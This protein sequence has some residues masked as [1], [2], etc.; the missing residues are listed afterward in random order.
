MEAQRFRGRMPTPLSQQPGDGVSSDCL[1]SQDIV[2]ASSQPTRHRDANLPTQTTRHRLAVD[3]HDSMDDM[4]ANLR[5][6]DKETMRNLRFT[7]LKKDVSN[8]PMVN[9]LAAIKITPTSTDRSALLHKDPPFITTPQGDSVCGVVI[10]LNALCLGFDVDQRISPEG[11][12]PTTQVLLTVFQNVFLALFVL[13]VCV[14]TKAEGW[15]YLKSTWGVFDVIVVAISVVDVWILEPLA[16]DQRLKEFSV[17]RILRLLRLARIMRLFHVCKELYLLASGLVASFSSVCWVFCLLFI[18][19]YMGA[20]FCTSL[21]GGQDDPELQ[22]YFGSVPFGVFSHF[23]VITLEQYPDIAAA[24]M[25]ENTGLWAFY[26]VIIITIASFAL[27]SLLTGVLADNVRQNAQAAVD[28]DREM[29]EW[30]MSMVREQIWQCFKNMD[31]DQSGTLN[32]EE[33]QEL[34]ADRDFQELL[35]A[36]DIGQEIGARQLFEIVDADDTGTVQAGELEV[37]LLRLRGSKSHIHTLF[38]QHDLKANCSRAMQRWARVEQMIEMLTP[39][40]ENLA[41]PNSQ[42]PNSEKKRVPGAK[43]PPKKSQTFAGVGGLSP[44]EEQPPE[45][46]EAASSIPMGGYTEEQE[47]NGEKPRPRSKLKRA[48]RSRAA[49][50]REDPAAGAGNFETA[51]EGER[52]D[53]NVNEEGDG[54]QSPSGW[55]SPREE[56]PDQEGEKMPNPMNVIP[57]TRRLGKSKKPKK[58]KSR[59]D[60]EGWASPREVDEADVGGGM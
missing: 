29:Y 53:R 15:I 14:R 20:L 49:D 5:N 11:P 33:F 43:K 42:P 51:G 56:A 21:L 17:L 12:S 47:G 48:S 8:S 30:E 37:E 32:F 46:E 13:E 22:G 3:I 19:S 18:L 52:E 39:A 2:V 23:K 24:I 40:L 50:H 57:I 41:G 44:S 6:A 7:Y 35:D 26:F 27:I 60:E 31:V 36:L 10:V 34:L 28:R 9:K 38:V 4:N 1:G 55:R 59:T 25:R 16:V 58:Y 54:A 45:Q